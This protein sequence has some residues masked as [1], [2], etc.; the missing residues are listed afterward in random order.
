MHFFGN[1]EEER[2]LSAV[3]LVRPIAVQTV[4]FDIELNALGA[5][6]PRGAS[7]VL[8][9]GPSRDVAPLTALALECRKV[10][11]DAGFEVE[12]RA[13]HAHCTLGRPR[14]PWS[15]D[16]RSAWT[17]VV[18]ESRP[19]MRFTATRL[20]LYESQPR[21]GGAMYT[22]RASLDFAARP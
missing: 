8:W 17:T 7:R 13:Y 2:A 1:V 3:E 19:L 5:F 22:E 6:P 15:A 12:Q 14:V 9:L 16:A 10:L 18:A 4:A 21:S 11:G 20:V